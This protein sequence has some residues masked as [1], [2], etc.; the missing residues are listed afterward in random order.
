MFEGIKVLGPRPLA[1]Q[2]AVGHDDH[3]GSAVGFHD[4]N[5]LA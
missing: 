4:A 2:I 1:N 3:G 5:G